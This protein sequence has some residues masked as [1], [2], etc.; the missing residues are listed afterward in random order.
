M[1]GSE[2][3][4]CIAPYGRLLGRE[5]SQDQGTAG[6]L[7]HRTE[8]FALGSLYYL[9]NYGLEVYGDQ[10]F[11]DDP[12]G[13][14]H[15]PVVLDL[16]QNMIFPELNR[17]PMIDSIIKKC[18]YGEY[19]TIAELAAD[20]EKLCGD[21]YETPNETCGAE[22]SGHTAAGNF[23]SQRK[24]CEDL[25]ACGVLRS[26]SSRNPRRLGLSMER[27]HVCWELLRA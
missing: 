16:L 15:G 18:W 11:G 27:R 24:L 20:T 13:R 4:A 9:I 19:R 2:F 12:S 6:L 25:V 21:G 5:S 1:I 23:S 10:C 8:Q 14:E 3:E 22:G 17:E 26:I 7:G